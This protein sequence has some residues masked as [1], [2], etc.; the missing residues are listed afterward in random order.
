MILLTTSSGSR[1]DNKGLFY[2]RQQNT[3]KKILIELYHA[4]TSRLR[5]CTLTVFLQISKSH[6]TVR[7]YFL[8]I[9]LIIFLIIFFGAMKILVVKDSDIITEII[10]EN[11]CS[12]QV[13]PYILILNKLLRKSSRNKPFTWHSQVL[14]KNTLKF[15]QY[16]TLKIF[17]VSWPFFNI[18]QKWEFNF[19][20][21]V[22]S[23]SFLYL[24]VIS[25]HLT[26]KCQW[27]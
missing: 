13:V 5:F 26:S 11:G 25:Y 16:L 6:W 21:T 24:T 3:S 8:N 2:T 14:A 22:S 7:S 15:F 27:I 23:L 9:C 20:S 18:F 17:N 12:L 19:D 4:K 10:F 1:K